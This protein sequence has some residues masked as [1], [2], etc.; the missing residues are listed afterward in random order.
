MG[1]TDFTLASTGDR[2]ILICLAPPFELSVAT[3]PRNHSPIR[4][5]NEAKQAAR[6]KRKLQTTARASVNP[7]RINALKNF[8]SGKMDLSK[9][10]RRCEQGKRI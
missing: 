2:E 8:P 7:D 3:A 1:W 5:Q 6:K 9:L 10:I 4:I